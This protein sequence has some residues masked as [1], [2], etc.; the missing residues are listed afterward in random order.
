MVFVAF[1]LIVPLSYAQDN[2][3]KDEKSEQ[4]EYNKK[5][6]IKDIRQ[7]LKSDRFTQA[8]DKIKKALQTYPEAKNDAEYYNYEIGIQHNLAAQENRKIY[9]DQKPDTAKYFNYVYEVYRYALLCDSLDTMPDAKGRIRQKYTSNVTDKL[10]YYR[11]NLKSGCKYFYKK[12]QWNDAD[13]FF[14]MYLSTINNIHISQKNI[15]ASADSAEIL[16][17]AFYSAYGKGNYQKAVNFLPRIQ[18]DTVSYAYT[19]QLA[20]KSLM[21]VKDTLQAVEYLYKGWKTDPT[22]KYFYVNLV[23]YHIDREQYDKALDVIVEQLPQDPL[24]HRL[25]Y[26]RGK[27]EQSIDSIDE[28][29]ISYQKAIQLQE[30]DAQ[31]YSSIGNI[32]IERARAAFNTIDYKRGTR[33]YTKAKQNQQN[34]YKEARESLEKAHQYAPD[35]RELWYSGLSE[36]YFK[37]NLGKE[38]K[39]LEKEVQTPAAAKEDADKGNGKQGG[40]QN[41]KKK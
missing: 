24:N 2:K 32:Y 30:D 7:E 5:K 3:N 25:W 28:A 13:K 33:A 14:D 4:P 18:E 26:V 6:T 40:N 20:S 35:D 36:I 1:M 19:C 27:C 23:E 11:N 21:E 17:L 38:L 15:Q 22:R 37:L 31:S 9:L 8:D 34:L 29:I 39:A 12:Q 16:R 41:N 10:N